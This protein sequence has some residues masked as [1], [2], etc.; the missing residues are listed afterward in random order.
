MSLF[1]RRREGGREGGGG[2]G[3]GGREGQ[4]GNAGTTISETAK[5]GNKGPDVRRW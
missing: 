1:E 2:R 4:G 5:R 3:G